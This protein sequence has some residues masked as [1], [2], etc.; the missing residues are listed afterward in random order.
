MF[1]TKRA[2]ALFEWTFLLSGRSK[3]DAQTPAQHRRSQSRQDQA[4]GTAP[5]YASG[6]PWDHGPP[7]CEQGRCVDGYAL[8]LLQ[9]QGRH[10]RRPGGRHGTEYGSGAAKRTSSLDEIDRSRVA[11]KIRAGHRSNRKRKPRLLAAHV[12]RCRGIPA[13]ALYPWLPGG[14]GRVTNLYKS[15]VSRLQGALSKTG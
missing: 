15:A 9:D 12:R 13:Q 6:V 8:H 3:G 1:P 14:C 4:V 5:I 10:F 11:E 2:L 7:D